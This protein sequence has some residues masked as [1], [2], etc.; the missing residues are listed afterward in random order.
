[1]KDVPHHMLKFIKSF[2]K[3]EN[4]KEDT[5]LK[6]YRKPMPER[7]KKKQKKAKKRKEKLKRTPKI[8]SPETRNKKMKKRTPKIR[9]RSHKTNI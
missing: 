5:S 8:D 3:E 2:S 7:Q 9:E 1:M 4:P 6:E